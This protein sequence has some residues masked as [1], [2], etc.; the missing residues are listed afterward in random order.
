MNNNL[1][2]YKIG[3]RDSLLALTQTT[4]VKRDLERITNNN[5][6]NIKFEIVSLKTSGDQNTSVPLWQLKGSNFFTKELDQALIDKRVDLVIHSFKDIGGA[7]PAEIMLAAVPQRTF[8]HDILL[9][10]N[11]T[12]KKL[13]SGEKKELV[14]GTSSPRRSYLLKKSLAPIFKSIN[15]DI[16]LKQRDLRGNVNTR[17]KKLYEGESEYEYDAIILALAGLERLFSGDCNTND[18]LQEYIDRLNF[19]VLPPSIFPWASAQGALAIECRAEE[20]KNNSP[21]F[22][23][24]QQIDHYQSRKIALAE[25]N[26]FN[27]YGGGCHQAIGVSIIEFDDVDD[28]HNHQIQICLGEKDG[29]DI[30]KTEI[31]EIREI[32][33][34]K[35][36]KNIFIG[37]PKH[38]QSDPQF[39]SDE[40]IEKVLI[41]INDNDNNNTKFSNAHLFV[42]SD[43]TIHTLKKDNNDQSLLIWCAG[44]KTMNKLLQKGFWVNGVGDYLGSKEILN[45]KKSAFL[46]KLSGVAEKKWYVLTREDAKEDLQIGE[47]VPCYRYKINDVSE[48]FIS[49]LK[50]TSTFYWTSSKQFEI[51]CQHFPFIIND[52]HIHA[53][54][55]G[56]TYQQLNLKKINVIPFTSIEEFKQWTKKQIN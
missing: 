5:I 54:G 52:N 39:L 51:Y 35:K 2:T 8:A 16:I 50:N 38:K 56:K 44:T 6:N 24:L 13:F 41:D 12:V 45:F 55:V 46:D 26:I 28:K 49:K 31:R 27:S 14:I 43:Y 21:L 19:L 22:Q 15:K 11:S 7:R 18:T 36:I 4:Q 25:K 17:L 48:E 3:S 23:L 34:E 53:T 32:T 30:S 37:L 47:H 33:E 40:L 42:T 20:E 1:I 10:K 9:I 29:E